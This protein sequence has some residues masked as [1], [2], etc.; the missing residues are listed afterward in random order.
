MGGSFENTFTKGGRQVTWYVGG[1]RP[2]EKS[3][4]V[5]RLLENDAKTHV[6]LFVRKKATEPYVHCGELGYVAHN[7]K[8]KGFQFT[9]ALKDFEILSSQPYFTPLFAKPSSEERQR[10]VT[11]RWA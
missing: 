3:P 6:V 7:P 8:K 1:V 5:R 4:I 2:T 11:R 10:A 9:W